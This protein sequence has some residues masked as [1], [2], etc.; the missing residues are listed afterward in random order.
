MPP[1]RMTIV[2]P[3]AMIALTAVWLATLIRFAAVRKFG[4]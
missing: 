4:Q 1:V 3:M 2:M